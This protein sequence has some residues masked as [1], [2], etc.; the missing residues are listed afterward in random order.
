MRKTKPIVVKAPKRLFKVV[1][2][3]LDPIALYPRAGDYVKVDT[4]LKREPRTT[5]V[6]WL[7]RINHAV[8]L[9][10]TLCFDHLSV[11]KIYQVL[12]CEFPG[13]GILQF[14]KDEK[15]EGVIGSRTSHSVPRKSGAQ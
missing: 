6:S 7:G 4:E 9:F 12:P 13:E 10:D 14:I 11:I 8:C 15:I 5:S 2:G 3:L 1:E